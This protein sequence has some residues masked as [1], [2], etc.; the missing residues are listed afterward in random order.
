VGLEF[1]RI[2][3]LSFTLTLANYQTVN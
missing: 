1:A 3:F 2:F